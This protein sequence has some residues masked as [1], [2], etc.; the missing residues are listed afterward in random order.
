MSLYP[1]YSLS[2]HASNELIVLVLQK[3]YSHIQINVHVH[4]YCHLIH[5]IGLTYY[6]NTS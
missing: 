5:T 4:K 1:A 2:F 6:C 3:E